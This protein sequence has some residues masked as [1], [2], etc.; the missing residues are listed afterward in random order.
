MK[1][2]EDLFERVAPK[3]E[4][5]VKGNAVVGTILSVGPRHAIPLVELSLSLGGGGGSGDGTDPATGGHGSGHGGAAGGGM[6]ATPVAVVVVEGNNVT[7]QPLG[8]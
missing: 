7:I 4:G 6:K 5:L 1:D 2:T 3:L 8:H